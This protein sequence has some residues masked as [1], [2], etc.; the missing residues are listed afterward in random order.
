MRL[1]YRKI[2]YEYS[3]I[4]QYIHIS[5]EHAYTRPIQANIIMAIFDVHA[6]T[7]QSMY[8]II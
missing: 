1:A 2:E 3:D 6:A 8:C 7:Q 4:A 5:L